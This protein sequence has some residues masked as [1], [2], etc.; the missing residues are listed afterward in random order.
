MIRRVYDI[1]VYS[2]LLGD[3]ESTKRAFGILFR[4][5]EFKWKDLWPLAIYMLNPHD[6][7]RD[8]T[9]FLDQVG[10]L[11]LLMLQ[12]HTQVSHSPSICV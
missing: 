7:D 4:C 5:K 10:Q 6:P 3:V 2:L 9:F 12:D 1:C 11:R 8:N